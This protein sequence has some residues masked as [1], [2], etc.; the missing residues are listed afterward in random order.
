MAR[1]DDAVGL[2]LR[3]A[4]HWQQL[5][6]IFSV[7]ELRFIETI[8]KHCYGDEVHECLVKH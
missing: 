7:A 4:K 8:E 3:N 6:C 5:K 2:A 1:P